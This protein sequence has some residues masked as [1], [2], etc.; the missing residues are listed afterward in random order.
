[1]L[2]EYVHQINQ[3]EEINT[4]VGFTYLSSI[5]SRTY[6]ETVRHVKNLQLQRCQQPL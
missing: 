3:G 6:S 5:L 4:D 1:M 2:E